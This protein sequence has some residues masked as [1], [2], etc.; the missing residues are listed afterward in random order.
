MFSACNG[1]P[2]NNP[3]DSRQYQVRYRI[4]PIQCPSDTVGFRNKDAGAACKDG[5]SKKKYDCETFYFFHKATS[6]VSGQIGL[7]EILNQ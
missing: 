5:E 7:L 2:N 4:A 3:N 6:P 1:P